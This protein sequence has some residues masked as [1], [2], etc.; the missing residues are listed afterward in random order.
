MP[1]SLISVDRHKLQ[2][3]FYEDLADAW[4]RQRQR[5]REE[6]PYAFV[7]YGVEDVPEFTA[8]V[9]TE[10]GLTRV[11]QRYVDQGYYETLRESC[12]ALRYSVAD[13]PT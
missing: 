7:L 5:A 3:A 12:E 10:E 6:T 8:H 1:K 9:L 2:A 13:S 4:R 11:A